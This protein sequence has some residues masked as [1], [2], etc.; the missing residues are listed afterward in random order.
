[1]RASRVLPP[2]GNRLGNNGAQTASDERRDSAE[3]AAAEPVPTSPIAAVTSAAQ[4]TEAANA[5]IITTDMH[6]RR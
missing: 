5:F 6:R 1:M 3:R 2:A 4:T